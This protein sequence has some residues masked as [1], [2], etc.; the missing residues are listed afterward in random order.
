[1]AIYS[2][3]V[4]HGDSNPVI[5]ADTKVNGGKIVAV[6]FDDA[7]KR[8][9]EF[10]DFLIELR[11]STTCGQAKHSIGEFMNKTPIRNKHAI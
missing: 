10:E 6:Q 3:V 11:D 1:M 2:Y 8:I 7:L 4:D 9:E 5:G